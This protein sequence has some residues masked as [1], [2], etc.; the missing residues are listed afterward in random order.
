MFFA[1]RR[2]TFNYELSL[3]IVPIRRDF[4]FLIQLPAVCFDFPGRQLRKLS[5]AYFQ[6]LV[7][8]LSFKGHRITILNCQIVIGIFLI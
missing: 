8:L 1:F 5:S 4:P 6:F 3:I 2:Q 7:P